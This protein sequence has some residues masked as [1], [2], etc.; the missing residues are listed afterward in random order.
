MLCN[1]QFGLSHL[2]L[3]GEVYSYNVC[4]G[5]H[6]SSIV[7]KQTIEEENVEWISIGMK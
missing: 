5:I 1:L 4:V 2:K 3:V 7:G 6:L